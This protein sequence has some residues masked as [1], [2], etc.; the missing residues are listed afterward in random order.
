MGCLL[1]ASN[2][3]RK[4]ISFLLMAR[5]TTTISHSPLGRLMMH[6]GAQRVG[7]DACV[8]LEQ[9]LHEY[10]VGIAKKADEIAKHAK[11]K[12]VI[13]GDVKLASR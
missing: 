13:A 9:F 1:I 12:T 8:E 7:E 5:N 3:N 10:A 2:C 6:A 11:R 4:Q